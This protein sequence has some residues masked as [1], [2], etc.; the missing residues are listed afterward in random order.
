MATCNN[1]TREHNIYSNI[2][3][4]LHMNRKTSKGMQIQQSRIHYN[5]KITNRTAT[6]ST[7]HK[8]HTHTAVVAGHA[9]TKD[10]CAMHPDREREKQKVNLDVY[11]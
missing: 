10:D 2:Q 6:G 4:L 1:T 3:H 5:L 9:Y 11:N 8:E 7:V